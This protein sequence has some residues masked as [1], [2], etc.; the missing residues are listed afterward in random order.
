V[1]ALLQYARLRSSFEIV[2]FVLFGIGL[3]LFQ[4]SWASAAEPALA[5]CTIERVPRGKHGETVVVVMHVTSDG[6]SC[7]LTPRVGKGEAE[8]ISIIEPPKNGKVAIA[9]PSAVYTPTLGF[10]GSDTFVVGWFGVGFGPNSRS[11]NFRTR[12][13][14]QVAAK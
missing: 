12:V 10:A 1:N 9:L 7:T 8:S 2:G 6:S 5:G 13:E 3:A 14:V 4:F 11:A